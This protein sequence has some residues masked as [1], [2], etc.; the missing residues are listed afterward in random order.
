MSADYIT[1]PCVLWLNNPFDLN[2]AEQSTVERDLTIRQWLDANG[3]DSRLNRDPTVCIYKGKELLRAEYDQVIESPVC[4]VTLPQ[5]G[6]DK[7]GGSN[8]F[9]I[10][11]MII[12]A[13]L[14]YGAGTAASAAY[15]G[16]SAAGFAASS[17]VMIAGSMLVNAV[18]PP[19]GL[20]SSADKSMGSPTYSA[21][22]QGNSARL[23]SPIPVN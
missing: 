11:A 8:P 7:K 16:S 22:A 14:S 12:V 15:G 9:Q 4:F 19:P 13:Y 23:G 21:G 5:G 20:P 18:F 2:D 17:A 1:S 3:G 10:I 6:N